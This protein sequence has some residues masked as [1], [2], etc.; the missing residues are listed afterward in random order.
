MFCFESELKDILL[1]KAKQCLSNLE[2]EYEKRNFDVNSG[3]VELNVSI[4]LN[5]IGIDFIAPMTI[6]KSGEARSFEGFK[7]NIES[8]MFEILAIA[9][10][11]VEFEAIFGSSDTN[12]LSLYY[13]DERIEK[14][15]LG[16][17]TT[18]YKITNILTNENFRFASRSVAW[19][20]GYGIG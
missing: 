3:D 18:I 14:N 15:E 7:I 5:A 8:K 16:D 19:P 17:G 10:T 9:K 6:T 1:P 11:I 13:R 20:P 12:T 4:S 2:T